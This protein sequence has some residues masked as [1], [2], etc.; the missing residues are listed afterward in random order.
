MT[1][2]K[3]EEELDAAKDQIM[4][5]LTGKRLPKKLIGL[6]TQISALQQL[7]QDSMANQESKGIL[8][9]GSHGTGKTAAVHQV[10]WR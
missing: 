4:D 1:T 2:D 7:V 10:A 9:L 3:L 6:E 5:R 8:L